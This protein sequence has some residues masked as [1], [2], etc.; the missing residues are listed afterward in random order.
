[1]SIE[2]DEAKRTLLDMKE[3]IVDLGSAL[4]IEE[5]KKSVEELESKTSAADF[6]NDAAES[7]KVLKELKVKKDKVERYDRL[8]S[9]YEDTLVLIEMALE[10]GDDSVTDEVL[11]EVKAITET[12]ASERLCF[13]ASMTP[14]MPFFRSIPVPAEPRLRTGLRCF[15]VCTHVGPSATTLR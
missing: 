10:E 1:M 4:Q 15:I 13:R 3:K 12:E 11:S 2:L 9:R 8:V 6:W 7:G 14:I 5:T